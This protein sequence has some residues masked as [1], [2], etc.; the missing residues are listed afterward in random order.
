ML[1]DNTNPTPEDRRPLIE[2]GRR[3]GAMAVGYH[4]ASGVREC[5]ERNDKREGKAEVPEVAI[6]ATAKKLVPP[7]YE[8]GFDEIFSVRIVGNSGFEVGVV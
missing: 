4:F 2:L 5:V 1:V 3:Y 6:Y 7:A 8:E